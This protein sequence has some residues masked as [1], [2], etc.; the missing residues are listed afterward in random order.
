MPG[1]RTRDRVVAG[2]APTGTLG[3]LRSVLRRTLRNPVIIGTLT[4]IALAALPFTLPDVVLQPLALLGAAAPPLALLTFGMSLAA[5]RV[6]G[7]AGH[8]LCSGWAG[9]SG[10][11]DSGKSS[12]SS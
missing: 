9:G 2:T 4:G 11:V 7:V 1:R 6:G 8:A 10:R 5:P 3:T 12:R